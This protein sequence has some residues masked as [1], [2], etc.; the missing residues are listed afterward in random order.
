M[1]QASGWAGTRS[2]QGESPSMGPFFFL[3]WFL[4]LFCTKLAVLLKT[5]RG[6]CCDGQ[7]V[8]VIAAFFAAQYL[9]RSSCEQEFS[10]V[11]QN[12]PSQPPLLLQHW[13]RTKILP[14]ERPLLQTS[15]QQQL[16][17]TGGWTQS[18]L[19][20]DCSRNGSCIWFLLSA[21]RAVTPRSNIG[22]AGNAICSVCQP[23]ANN[24]CWSHLHPSALFVDPLN[25]IPNPSGKCRTFPTS[26]IKLYIPL[27]LVTFV[28]V[29]WNWKV[30][31]VQWL[32]FGL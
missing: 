6:N 15:H 28:S 9:N 24:V 5:M 18:F 26:Y 17:H 1:R 21:G 23:T 12:L 32:V 27:K 31:L 16:A 14:D 25:L 3:F 2:E 22:S 29:P 4:W 7:R 13:S 8:V 10:L 19:V 11:L 20:V 30:W